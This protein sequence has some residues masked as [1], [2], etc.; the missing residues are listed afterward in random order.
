MNVLHLTG[1]NEDAGGILSVLRSLDAEFSH[2][3]VAQSV[4][5]N[6]SF[7][8]TRTPALNLFRSKHVC[9]F[10]PS[11]LR[12]MWSAVRASF[13]LR[14]VLEHHHIDIIHAHSQGTILAGILANRRLQRGMVF[15]NHAY[16]RNRRLYRY[17]SR[18]PGMHTV[19]LT[20][21]MAK[22][23]GLSRKNAVRNH[24]I[25][26]CCAREFFDR[27]LADGQS[28]SRRILRL[29]GVGTI[30]RWKKWHLVLDALRLLKEE[31]RE[32]IRVDVWGGRSKVGDSFEYA[33]ELENDIRAAGLDKTMILRGT[34]TDVPSKIMQA[35]WFV[36]PSTNEPCSVALIEA[37]A[38]GKP[39][40]VSK[41]GG[42]VD[43]LCEKKSGLFFEPDNVESLKRVL[44]IVLTHPLRDQSPESI[45]GTVSTRASHVVAR[46][47]FELYS[48]VCGK[49]Q[50]RSRGGPTVS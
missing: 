48:N 30:M 35:D 16:A 37:L 42:N 18:L 44:Q 14:Q 31:E 25:S 4:W 34:T 22:Y 41:S 1:D 15:T 2:L 13:E 11:Y 19:S 6:Q 9:G 24:I 47:Y 20:P 27:P 5:V 38:L 28:P 36:L 33:R 26:E 10:H 46:Q 49:A 43:I 3:G 39:A 7:R 21:N 8:E 50:V 40:L 12:L 17:V 29:V 23:Y 45:R 32:R